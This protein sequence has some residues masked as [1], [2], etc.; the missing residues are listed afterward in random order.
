MCFFAFLFPSLAPLAFFSFEKQTME[1]TNT[2][3][4]KQERL[5]NV[6]KV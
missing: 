5:T 4:A 1:K 6:T 2:T 3:I